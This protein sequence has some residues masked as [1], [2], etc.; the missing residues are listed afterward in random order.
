MPPKAQMAPISRSNRPTIVG[1][2]E[3]EAPYPLRLEGT[4]T[5]GFGRGARYLGIPT[6]ISC[7]PVMT[8]ILLTNTWLFQPIFRTSRWVPSTISASQVS[9]TAS[10]VFITPYP[11]L[12]HPLS[13]LPLSPNP[14][15]L[16]LR[17][18]KSRAKLN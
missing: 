10:P 4:V 11:P 9:T 5:K 15:H 17:E 8:Y 3:P 6:G 12:F 13:P 16:A 7:L 14:L 1:A 2:D 18:R